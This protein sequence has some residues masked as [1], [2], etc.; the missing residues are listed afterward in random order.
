MPVR[1]WFHLLVGAQVVFLAAWAGYHEA[2]LS[3]APTVLLDTRPVDPSEIIRGDYIILNYAIAT[4]PRSTFAP[5]L[6]TSG[7]YGETVCVTLAPQG[8]F[9]GLAA[10]ALGRCPCEAPPS[11]ERY[12]VEGMIAGG[13]WNDTGDLEVDYGIGRYYVPEGKGTP[14]GKVTARVA[15]TS[16]CRALLK[17][18]YLD[19]RRYP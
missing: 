11:G 7:H 5:P 17:E 9:W 18:I 3:G 14:R 13:G 15:V 1:R 10:A 6:D 19:G 8:E 12:Q 4:V 2:A 16:N